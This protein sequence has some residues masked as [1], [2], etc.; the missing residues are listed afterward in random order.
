MRINKINYTVGVV[1]LGYVGLPLAVEFGQKVLTLGYDI[2][3]NKIT[4]F[5]KKIDETRNISKNKFLLAKKLLFTNDP[6]LLSRC[7]HI[8]ICIPTPVNK[9][10]EPDLNSLKKATILVAKFMKKGTIVTYESTVYP[11]FTED[12]CVPII[13][14]F[15]GYKWKKH[16]NIGYSPERINPGD[17][18]NNISNITKIVSADS[19]KTQRKLYFLY[20]KIIKK[21]YMCSSIKIA[22]AAKIIEN[23][24][25]DINISLMN[26]FSIICRKLNIN[27]SEVLAAAAT[28]WNFIKFSPGLV[29]G[30]CIGVD[31]YYLAYKAKNLKYNPKVILAGRTLNESM[32]ANV[33]NLIKKNSSINKK[34]T[35]FIGVTFKENCS[36]VR[37]SKNLEL[38]KLFL[39]N[40]NN[41]TICDYKANLADLDANIKDKVLN[42]NNIKNEK[43]D[44]IILAVPH[45]K[46]RMFSENKYISLLK[47]KGL[48]VDLKGIFNQE[49]F[50]KKNINY[51][52]M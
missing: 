24:Q 16:F 39:R 46:Y 31:P 32:T 38:L 35:L 40:N 7:R 28:K 50:K 33:Y 8:I 52:T 36:D 3:E 27:T 2:S 4:N 44:L 43:F 9:N 49:Y 37:N 21:I 11:S 14:K 34:K 47:V 22:E 5:K 12:Y 48:F 20:S 18:M 51:L 29:G 25:R 45:A 41:V 6:K 42:I 23:T 30:H 19:I 15:S 1:G 10:N 17:K 13:E 26:E